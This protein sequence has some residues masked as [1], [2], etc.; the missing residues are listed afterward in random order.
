MRQE[1]AVRQGSALLF[2]GRRLLKTR[3]LKAIRACLQF[4][5]A[6]AGLALDRPACRVLRQSEPR[7]RPNSARER[8]EP[9]LFKSATRTHCAETGRGE[10]SLPTLR[11]RLHSTGNKKAQ[12]RISLPAPHLRPQKTRYQP[13]ARCRRARVSSRPRKAMISLRCEPP[14]KPMSAVRSGGATSLN[15]RPL[16][17]T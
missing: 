2:Y 11:L 6:G 8:R 9:F 3:W 7:I 13:A 4:F 16:S 12:A 14:I 15:F 1:K 17:A 10:A 5:K